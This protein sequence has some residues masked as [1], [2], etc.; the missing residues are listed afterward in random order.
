MLGNRGLARSGEAGKPHYR[1]FMA[2][3]PFSLLP[4]EVS[5][6]LGQVIWVI[7][8]IVDSLITL[9]MTDVVDYVE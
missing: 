1:A 8:Q 5:V 7:R 9:V 2:V 4:G 6:V 3:E